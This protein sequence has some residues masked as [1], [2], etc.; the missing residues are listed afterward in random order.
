MNIENLHRQ[1]AGILNEV[2]YLL[3]AAQQPDYA[4]HLGEITLRINKLA[5]QLN[6][7]LMSEDNYLYPSLLRSRNARIRDI[8]TRYNQE[9]GGLVAAFQEYKDRFNAPFKIKADG[10]AFVSQTKLVMDSIAH[11]IQKEDGQLYPLI[12]ATANSN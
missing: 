7:H 8:A 6:M 4:D 2:R 12:A 9:M 11:R 10:D 5:G 3:A 1:H